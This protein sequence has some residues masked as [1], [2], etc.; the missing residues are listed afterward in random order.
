M[1]PLLLLMAIL[2]SSK[3]LTADAEDSPLRFATRSR[4]EDGA[5]KYQIKEQALN[6][7]PHKTAL[8]ICDMWDAH[9][10]PNAAAR[11][12]ELAPR[13]D[14]FAKAARARGVFVIH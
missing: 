5:G 4:V 6:W 9:T 11:V 3:V 12:N 1:K 14:A 2:W 7:D 13:V 10:C 8:V